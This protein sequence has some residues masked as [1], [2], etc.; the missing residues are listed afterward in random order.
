MKF[1]H[2]IF[3][4]LTNNTSCLKPE[5]FCQI[6]KA[7][8]CKFYQCA[9]D[10]CS[11]NKQ[12][13]DRFKEWITLLDKYKKFNFIEIKLKTLQKFL[14]DIELCSDEDFEFDF[15]KVCFITKKCYERKI[16]STRLMFKGVNYIKIE[17]CIC[18]GDFKTSCGKG[19]CAFDNKNCDL[20]NSANFEMRKKAKKCL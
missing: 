2:L 12:S 6:N 3:L 4:F 17:K 10:L 1:F 16:W 8:K 9:Y 20:I 14:T 15:K 18:N 13:C 19:Y 5:Y 11:M 7:E